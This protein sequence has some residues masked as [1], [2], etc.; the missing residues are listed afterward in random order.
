MP[1]LNLQD[2]QH[3][4]LLSIFHYV[5][6]ALVILFSCIFII[7]LAMG[8]AAL[9]NP[10]IMKNAKGQIP[11][12]FF[13]WL[14]VAFGSIAI[15][16]GWTLGICIIAA[17]KSLAGRKRYWFCF[18]MAAVSCM[19]TPFGTV[20]GVFTLIVLSRPSVKAIFNVSP[21]AGSPP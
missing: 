21:S 1:E 3:L 11:P 6:G 20:L 5:V 7:H 9:V 14:F 8:I 17:G 4:R 13:G 16:I 12:P 2:E 10:Q 19:F 15:I 18:V